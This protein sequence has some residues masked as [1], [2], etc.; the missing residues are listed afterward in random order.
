MM[1]SHSHIDKVLLLILVIGL[2]DNF[3]FVCGSTMELFACQTCESCYHAECMTPSLDPG[4]VPKFW[5]CPHCVDQELHI[6][7]SP[8]GLRYVQPNSSNTPAYPSPDSGVLSPEKRSGVSDHT[9]SSNPVVLNVETEIPQRQSV[10]QN[11][12][13]AP[14]NKT[15]DSGHATK[16]GTK[17]RSRPIESSKFGDAPGGKP[18]RSSRISS[19]PRKKSKYSAF[20]VEVD[21]ALAVL[22]A[23]LETAAQF[24]KAEGHLESK[25]L[26]LEQKLKLQ[27]GQLLLSNRELDFARNHLTKE[28]AIS[29]L[30]K[31]ENVD[32]KNEV[33]KL[34]DQLQH[35]NDALRDWR[36]KLRTMVGSDLE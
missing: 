12:F 3:C 25:V 11:N 9:T 29:G 20:S 6:P 26:D 18:G 16:P 2:H 15:S 7:S 17:S 35:K 21:K 27:D 14:F 10:T 31:K 28:Q 22:Y 30:L 4:D 33:S 32:L 34:Q 24:G 1:V 23:E 13:S 5:F 19:P 8:S 36:T